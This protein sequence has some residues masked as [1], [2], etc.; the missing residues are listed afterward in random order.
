MIIEWK[1]NA[2]SLKYIC[3]IEPQK[4][5]ES[6]NYL[7]QKD[8]VKN[9]LSPSEKTGFVEECSNTERR[10]R[11]RSTIVWLITIRRNEE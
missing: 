1:V 6:D 2:S 10:H 9:Y 4:Q 7:I 5:R 8:A 3:M 11:K